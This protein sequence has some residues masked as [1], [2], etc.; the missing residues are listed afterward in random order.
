LYRYDLQTSISSF[1][2]TDIFSKV[3]IDELVFHQ[4][5]E[6]EAGLYLLNM[7]TDERTTLVDRPVYQF[8]V[9]SQNERLIFGIEDG[10]YF[11]QSDLDG[12]NQEELLDGQRL[13]SFAFNG[14]VIAVSTRGRDYPRNKYFYILDGAAEVQAVIQHDFDIT[15]VFF[16]GKYV[17]NRVRADNGFASDL[18]LFDLDDLDSYWIFVRD[19]R[20]L[21]SI[22]NYIIYNHWDDDGDIYRMS[23]R[24]RSDFIRPMWYGWDD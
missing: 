4:T 13:T 11:Y 3:I 1:I 9:D 6:F 12:T 8:F 7:D 10:G 16:V 15:N 5:G 2:A 22:G 23:L 20:Y 24:G 14:D 18:Y 17:L 21:A 19:V